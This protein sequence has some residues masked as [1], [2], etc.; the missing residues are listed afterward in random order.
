MWKVIEGTE[1][2]MEVSDDGRIRSLLTPRMTEL[3]CQED[4]K[5]YC[6]VRV[7]INRVKRTFKVHREVAKAFIPNPYN[8][9]QVNHIDGNKKN[10]RADNLEWCTNR[11]NVIH[12]F[13]SG[14]YRPEKAIN[15]ISINDI[16]FSVYDK[17]RTHKRKNRIITNTKLSCN[18]KPI[19]G[20]KDGCTKYFES[21]S[22]AEFFLDSRHISDVLK[23]KRNH[24][25]GW[26]FVYAEG[27]ESIAN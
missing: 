9:P 27:R 19:I 10:N 24:V 5:G 16:D 13:E 18:R 14:F 12:A 26:S 3:K 25:K 7:T 1:G 21:V 22:E 4:G 8:L 23:G 17:R 6:R 20:T 11:Q 2:M 15:P